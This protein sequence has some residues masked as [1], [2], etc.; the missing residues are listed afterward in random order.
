MKKSILLCFCLGL[1]MSQAFAGGLPKASVQVLVKSLQDAS[2]EVRTAAALA[3]AAIPDAAED[4]VKPLETALVAGAD[5]G[6][7]DAL[8]KA[9]LAANDSGTPKRLS[10][11]LVNPQFTW[12]AGAK[13]KAVELVGK[14]GQKKMI[15]WLTAIASGEQ[16]P[17]IRAAAIHMLG[18]IGA[19]P[20]K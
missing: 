8:T 19:P 4:A 18:D 10:E 20:K 9:L 11:F 6:E 5:G 15:K 13:V 12:G 2:P 14:I 16:D 7:L 17:P 1:G 3:L